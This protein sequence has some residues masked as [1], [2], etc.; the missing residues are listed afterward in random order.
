MA[1]I[2]NAAIFVLAALMLLCVCAMSA[3]CS[4][5]DKIK[6]LQQKNAELENK[7]EEQDGKINGLESEIN[8]QNGKIAELEKENTNLS[9]R[10][11]DLELQFELQ[12]VKGNLC[13]LSKAYYLG[14]LSKDDLKSIAYYH[15]DMPGSNYQ[16]NVLASGFIP[17]PKN[18]E[19][20]SEETDVAIR[21]AY[22]SNKKPDNSDKTIEDVKYKYYGTYNN[23]IAVQMWLHYDG[24]ITEL[25]RP[26][27]ID[28]VWFSF[29]SWYDLLI[30]VNN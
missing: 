3:G 16:E 27:Y 5:G 10:I 25:S 22:Y 12:A 28:D 14:L 18:P 19:V 23:C 6:E 24:I 4:D 1:K 8:D 17:A 26:V 7:I 20:L 11:K 9:D 30:W 21:Q 29:S 15:H 2:K 13:S